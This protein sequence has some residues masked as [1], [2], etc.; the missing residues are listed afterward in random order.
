MKKKHVLIASAVVATIGAG[1]FLIGPKPEAKRDNTALV[2]ESGAT[3]IEVND[4]KHDRT[5]EVS[6]WEPDTGINRLVVL[7]HGFNG[8]R[9]SHNTLAMGLVDAGFVVAAPTHP[10]LGG[11][12]DANPDLDPLV[13]RPRH[14]QLTI[15]RMLEGRSTEITDVT[16]IGH[17]LGGYTALRAAGATP[18]TGEL[19]LHCERHRDDDI[20]CS[21]SARSRIDSLVANPENVSTTSIDRI[22]LLAPGYGPLFTDEA[23]KALEQPAMV[24]RAESDSEI[25]GNQ[26]ERLQQTLRDS[27]TSTVPGSHYVFNRPCTPDEQAELVDICNDQAGVDRD[28]IQD[29]VT[30]EIVDFIADA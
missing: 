22:V 9:T 23:L 13:L 19:E 26:V 8:D 25:V 1:L 3:T 14:L 6:V 7:S 24:V 30:K 21:D 20:L 2:A 29:D 17:S 18:T 10:D 4:P 11:L 15:N 28:T 5:I 12:E 16:V 27:T